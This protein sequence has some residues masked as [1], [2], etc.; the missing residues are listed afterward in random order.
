VATREDLRRIALALPETATDNDGFSYTVAGKSIVWRLRA[1]K[2][3]LRTVEME[4]TTRA[5]PQNQ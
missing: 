4:Q 2:A 5:R 3:L 1:P